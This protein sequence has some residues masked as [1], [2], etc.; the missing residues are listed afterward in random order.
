MN[1][2][3]YI[4]ENQAF[5]VCTKL[6]TRLGVSPSTVRLYFIYTSCL[7]LGS[8]LIVYLFVGFWIEFRKHLRRNQ[9]PTVW[10]FGE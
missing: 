1:N 2:L 5:G 8:P 10:E 3:K 4:V 9:N 6:G 7:T